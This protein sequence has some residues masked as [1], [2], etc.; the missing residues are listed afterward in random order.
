MLGS[1]LAPRAEQAS[2]NLSYGNGAPGMVGSSIGHTVEPG[3]NNLF[4]GASYG[5]MSVQNTVNENLVLLIFPQSSLNPLNQRFADRTTDG[6]LA[7]PGNSY[8]SPKQPSYQQALPVY[9]NRGPACRNDSTPSIIPIN[10]SNRHQKLIIK[11]RVAAKTHV[12]HWGSNNV[13]RSFSFDVFDAGGEIRVTC[14]NQRVDQFYDLI[15]VDKVYLISGGNLKAANKKYNHL[16]NHWEIIPDISTSIQVCSGD[17]FNIPQQQYNFRQISEIENIENKSMVDLLGVVTSV[18]PS[19]TIM[20]KNGTET[21]KRTHQLL[22]TSGRSVE[23]TFWENFCDV[24]GKQLQLKYDSGLNPILSLKR[25]R[26][27]DFGG[28]SLSTINSTQLKIDPDFPDAE[29]LKQWY[30]TEGKAAACISLSQGT[31][32]IGQNVVR[33]TI[34]QIKDENLGQSDTPDWI[35]IKAEISYVRSENFYYPACLLM[36][37]EKPCNKKVI[38]NGDGM[39]QCERC[40]KIFEN[41]EYR[42]LV[43]F[44]IQDHT[45]TT[46]VTSF[47]DVGKQIFGCPAQELLSIRNVNQD[48]ALF[49]EIIEGARW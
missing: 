45:G 30:I 42:Y 21:Q 2:N 35:T 47:Q 25:V 18:G 8:G 31:S 5:T 33:K 1:S 7:P 41:C 36:L 27:S 26:V 23:V 24:E 16:N 14:F 38:Q 19:V 49:T 48:D 13:G 29:K 39:W 10:A 20:R 12:R 4:T 11:A 46:Y 3:Q 9:I 32:N 15:E 43:T 40:N 34:A 17:D 22:D 28:R 37:D 44:Q 6:G